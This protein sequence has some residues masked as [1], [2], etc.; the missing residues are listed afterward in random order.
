MSTDVL[1]WVDGKRRYE[2]GALVTYL[3][4]ALPITAITFG[5]W[6]WLYYWIR[7]KDGILPFGF[8]YEK[9]LNILRRRLGIGWF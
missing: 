7:R 1:H 2:S 9:Q 4:L 8:T 5:M 6:Y 3:A